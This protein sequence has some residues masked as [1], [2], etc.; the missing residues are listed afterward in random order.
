MGSLPW[1]ALACCGHARVLAETGPR[2]SAGRAVAL[3]REANKLGTDLG[4]GWVQR[5]TD[6]QLGTIG[7]EK[8]S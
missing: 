6:Q 1:L 7:R 8:I 4:M 2:E 3:L 5:W